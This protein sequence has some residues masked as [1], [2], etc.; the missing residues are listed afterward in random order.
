MVSLLPQGRRARQSAA[1]RSRNPSSIPLWTYTVTSPAD[2]LTYTGKMVGA[3]PYFNG[4][5]TTNVPTVVI[6]LIIKMPD[7]G[8]YDPTAS[9]RC[10]TWGNSITQVLASPIFQPSFYTMKGIN[11]G[12]GQYI[13]E[14]QR[15]NFYNANVSATGDSYHTVLSPVTT[16]AAQTIS[17]P[18]NQ[19]TSMFLGGCALV[20]IMDLGTFDSIISNSLIPSLTAQGLLDQSSFPIFIIHDVV[21][22][23]PGTDISSHCCVIGYHSALGTSSGVQ[24]YAVADFDTSR[25]F[26]NPDIQPLSHEVGE[27][28]DDPYGTNPTPKWGHIGQVIN[29]QGNLEVGDPLSGIPPAL[30]Q[31]NG[32][33]GVTMSNGH[34]YYPQDLAFFSWFYRQSPSLGVGGVY[35]AASTLLSPPFSICQG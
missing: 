18:N 27:W 30:Y 13:D 25:T 9:D 31:T 6:P 11:M 19:G 10:T 1:P 15:G 20:G 14:F 2:G 24:T 16:L 12:T 22:G 33:Y 32:N 29:C 34:T 23:N 26:Q 8:V 35:S 4:A 3:S 7:G 28:M 17:I 5:R 21:M